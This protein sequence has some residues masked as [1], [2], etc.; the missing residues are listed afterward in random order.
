MARA[1]NIKPGFFRNADLVE[2]S[3]EARLLFIGLW[4]IAD[5]EGRLEDRPKQ[6]K[7]ELFP[8]DNLDCELILNSLAEI[9]MITRYVHDGKRYLQVVNFLKHQN[10]HKDE[11]A[12]TIHS[13]GKHSASTVQAPCNDSATSEVVGLIADSLLLNPESKAIGD[14]IESPNTALSKNKKKSDSIGRRFTEDDVL[15]PEWVAYCNQVRPDLNPQSIFEDF[16]C[17]WISKSGADARK[18]NWYLTSVDRLDSCCSMMAFQSRC[19]CDRNV[20][21]CSIELYLTFLSYP[22]KSETYSETSS[23]SSYFS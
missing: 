17:H 6:I 8:A 18:T 19:A 21:Y 9:G 16:R 1:R 13:N 10:P 15:K 2:L 12:S 20:S 11:R 14:S 23:P 4:T 5:R 22:R 3:F 7:M